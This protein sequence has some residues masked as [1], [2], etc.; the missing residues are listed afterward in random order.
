MDMTEYSH[1]YKT[2]AL[3][4]YR[5]SEAVFFHK[6]V[7]LWPRGC[8]DYDT[9]VPHLFDRKTDAESIDYLNFR[10]AEVGFPAALND[11]T[12]VEV[13]SA[14]GLERI[15]DLDV[16]GTPRVWT[17]HSRYVLFKYVEPH[18]CLPSDHLAPGLRFLGEHE[19]MPYPGTMIEGQLVHW[20]VSPDHFSPMELPAEFRSDTA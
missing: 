14:T 9:L 12:V 5:F 1:N 16:D 7:P 13:F 2:P 17:P 19:F 18:K 15:A 4:R 6:V 10:D 20:E 8:N 3:R 11:V